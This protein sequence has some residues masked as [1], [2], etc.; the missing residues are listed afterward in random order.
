MALYGTILTTVL[1]IISVVMAL[2]KSYGWKQKRKQREITAQNDI[3][4]SID[5][6]RVNYVDAFK[7]LGLIKKKDDITISF[8]LEEL[9]H[10]NTMDRIKN[11]YPGIYNDMME[12]NNKAKFLKHRKGKPLL[13]KETI[14]TRGGWPV[15]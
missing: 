13:F 5:N 4:R 14:D 8:V 10:M 11:E 1:V 15:K 6:M 12:I 9:K 3:K 2:C 7:A